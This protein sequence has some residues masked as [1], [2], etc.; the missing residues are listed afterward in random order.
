MNEWRRSVHDGHFPESPTLTEYI[1]RNHLRNCLVPPDEV[2]QDDGEKKWRDPTGR[3]CLCCCLSCWCSYVPALDATTTSTSRSRPRDR[4]RMITGPAR[5]NTLLRI[6]FT[7]RTTSSKMIS[8]RQVTFFFRIQTFCKSRAQFSNLFR[9][10]S[11]IVS[12]RTRGELRSADRNSA[13]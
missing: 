1:R 6:H 12:C 10:P 5:M 4:I 2:A 3:K 8:F 11:Q 7:S 9:C 13:A